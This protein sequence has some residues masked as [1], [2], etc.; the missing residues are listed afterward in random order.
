MNEREIKEWLSRAYKVD[1]EIKLL[2][3]EKSRIYSAA[4]GGGI[5]FEARISGENIY[6]AEYRMKK[7]SEYT[8]LIDNKIA[9][10]MS[11]KAEIYKVISKVSDSAERKVLFCRYVLFLRWEKIAEC[12]H[13]EERQIY[14]IHDK[15]IKDVSECQSAIV[16]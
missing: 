13:Y 8:I 11:V 15:A 7:Y 2:K 3:I 16:I 5:G 10:L 12:L 1:E 9:E 6:N 4:S 14:R